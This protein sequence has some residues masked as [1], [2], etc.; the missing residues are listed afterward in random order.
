MRASTAL[1]LTLMSTNTIADIYT[2]EINHRTIYSDTPCSDINKNIQMSQDPNKNT[3]WWEHSQHHN[4]YKQPIMLNGALDQRVDKVATIINNAWSKS[5]NCQASISTNNESADCKDF[6]Q[7]IEPGTVFWQASHQY[8]ALNP[9]IKKKVKD[10]DKLLT[11]E[12]QIHELIEF[13][14]YLKN[15]VQERQ[16]AQR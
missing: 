3:N 2:C 14:R 1:L 15:Y 12:N 13:R 6:T 16:L 5:G 9:Y 10:Q 8:Q 7:F 4:Q 11:I